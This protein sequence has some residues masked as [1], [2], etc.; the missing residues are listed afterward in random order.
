MINKLIINK[1]KM[2]NKQIKNKCTI[3]K[4][5]ITTKTL[6]RSIEMEYFPCKHLGCFALIFLSIKTLV[7]L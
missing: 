3:L 2:I 5:K 4:I 1:Q 7:K 6:K